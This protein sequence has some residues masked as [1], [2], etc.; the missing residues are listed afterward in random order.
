MIVNGEDQ[1]DRAPDDRFAS[2]LSKMDIS[3]KTADLSFC[4]HLFAL[5]DRSVA[6]IRPFARKLADREAFVEMSSVSSGRI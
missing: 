2:Y 5:C 4:T 3:R 6:A 1:Y